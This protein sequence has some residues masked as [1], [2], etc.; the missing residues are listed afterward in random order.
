MADDATRAEGDRMTAY[1]TEPPS[2]SL[3]DVSNEGPFMA[4][5]GPI[6]GRQDG[7]G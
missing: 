7:Q 6:P 2:V 5:A 1:G 3:S 4:E